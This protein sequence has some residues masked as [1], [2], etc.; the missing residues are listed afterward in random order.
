M[1]DLRIIDGKANE[2]A[3]VLQL[4]DYLPPRRKSSRQKK[5]RTKSQYERY[6]LPFFS[7][8]GCTWNVVP[9]G[10]Y[11]A[12][13]ET[14]NRYAMEFLK[15]CDGSCGWSSLLQNIVADMIRA[16]PNGTFAGGS[17]KTNGI[18]IGFMGTIGRVVWHPSSRAC[19]TKANG[20]GGS[21]PA[22]IN[23]PAPAF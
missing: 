15:S 17:P 23:G 3:A 1:T 4:S 10:D 6:P 9:S 2:S 12:D 8:R 13:C 14:G 5:P 16:G 18:V 20:T 7:K 11:G 21:R 22:G 19:S